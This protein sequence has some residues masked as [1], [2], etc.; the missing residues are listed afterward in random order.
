MECVKVFSSEKGPVSLLRAGEDRLYALGDFSSEKSFGIDFGKI[1]LKGDSFVLDAV[2]ETS[3]LTFSYEKRP[4]LEG[5]K[6]IDKH[7]C[8][9]DGAEVESYYEF[10]KK[11]YRLGKDAFKKRYSMIITRNNVR[12]AVADEC[13]PVLEGIV[14][15][16][17]DYGDKQYS[18]VTVG[19]EKLYVSGALTVGEKASLAIDLDNVGVATEDNSTI[20]F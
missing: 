18:V 9:F 4:S 1:G 17:A 10:N 19:S 3:V 7:F 2:G 8:V 13:Y 5:K 14:T 16:V 15:D 12:P 20:L 6:K 11:M